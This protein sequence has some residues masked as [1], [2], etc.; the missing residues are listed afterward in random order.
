MLIGGTTRLSHVRELLKNETYTPVVLKSGKPGFP[1]RAAASIWLCD[2]S[3]ASLGPH[4]ELQ[5]SFYVSSGE[6]PVQSHNP[7]AI[8]RMLLNKPAVRVFSYRLWNDMDEVVT[9]NREVLGLECRQGDA[10][11]FTNQEDGVMTFIFRDLETGSAIIS[12]QVHLPV[13]Q[14]AL[15]VVSL[16]GLPGCQEDFPFFSKTRGSHG[17]RQP[18]QG[19]GRTQ[20]RS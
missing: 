18:N 17:R 14:S 8:L 12:G 7:Y 3:K 11:F 1:D 16:A 9:F 5:L 6:Y 20:R 13:R 4:K 10:L 15:E 2:F 19:N